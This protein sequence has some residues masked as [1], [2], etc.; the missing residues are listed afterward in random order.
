MNH[1]GLFHMPTQSFPT[2]VTAPGPSQLSSPSSA[3]SQD[4]DPSV[5]PPRPEHKDEPSEA[6]EDDIAASASL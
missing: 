5:N 1:T 2:D 4:N 3:G 6:G